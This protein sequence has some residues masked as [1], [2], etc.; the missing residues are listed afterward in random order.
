[1]SATSSYGQHNPSAPSDVRAEFRALISECGVYELSSRAKIRLTGSDCVRWLN[2]MVTNNIRDLAPD[3]G[4]YAFL[5]N[6]Q[7]HI[8]ADIY[9]YHRGES[10]LLD[11]GQSQLKKLLEIF[12]H[13]IIMDDVEVADVS[14]ELASFGITGP[15]SPA[16]L[17]SAGIEAPVLQPLQSADLS[18]N[19]TDLTV[20][21]SDNPLLDSYE[22]WLAPSQ[23]GP[24]RQALVKAGASPVGSNA[25]ELLRIASG[26]PL[27]GTDIRERDLPQETEQA[28]ALNFHKGCYIGQEIVERIRSRG[29]V[30]RKFT[31]FLIDGPLPRP[32]VTIQADDKNIGEITS[33]ASLPLA[34]GERK[35]ALGYLRREAATPGKEF[36]A[37]GS[38]VIVTNLPF[39][40]ALEQ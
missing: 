23:A 36:Q 15:M 35:F 37:G 24:L 18:W 17:A 2:G 7:G 26:I 25:L 13:Y 22:L 40:E 21:R 12:D 34:N 32:G 29:A 27:L 28:R 8:Q 31:G 16:V 5:L 14:Q 9:A 3:H 4:V 20:I 19:G 33:V 39:V 11:A 30:H 10:L 1:M 38:K 6:P